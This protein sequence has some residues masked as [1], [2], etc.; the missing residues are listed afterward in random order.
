[1]AALY[2]LIR[3]PSHEQLVYSP[4]SMNFLERYID[5]VLDLLARGARLKFFPCVLR[6]VCVMIATCSLLFVALNGS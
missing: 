4:E 6:A 5:T 2:S 1:M 3:Q